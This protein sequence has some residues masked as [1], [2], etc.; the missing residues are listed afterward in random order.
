MMILLLLRIF[1][2]INFCE[3][4]SFICD[5][6]LVPYGGTI[7]DEYYILTA[8]HCVDTSISGFTFSNMSIAFGINKL[9]QTNKI[10]RRIKKVIVHPLWTSDGYSFLYDIAIISLNQNRT[11]TRICLPSRGRLNTTAPTSDSLQQVTLKLIDQRDKICASEILNSSSQFCA[12]LYEG[13]KGDSGGPIFQWIGD[14]WE[15]IGISSYIEIG[16]AIKGYFDCDG[17][18]RNVLLSSNEM[19]LYENTLPYSWS[20]IVSIRYQNQHLCTGTILD[21]YLIKDLIIY[22]GIYYLSENDPI[23][24]SILIKFLFIQ[25]ITNI[26]EQATIFEINSLY[27]NC[28]LYVNQYQIQFCAGDLNQKDICYGGDSG[29]SVFYWDGYHWIQIGLSSYCKISNNLGVFTRLDMYSNW[30]WSI[31][32][33]NQQDRINVYSCDTMIWGSSKVFGGIT[34]VLKQVSVQILLL[35]IS[36][37]FVFDL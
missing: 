25:I 4:S 21:N 17:A 27:S 22:A 2:L 16:C 3:T 6:N 33:S 12:G 8:A 14:R 9:S 36:I 29:N 1:L 15:Q 32:D 31:V 18:C 34:D 30:I 35:M 7:L 26:L 19:I 24:R 37:D 13:G 11:L 5:K 23:I 10:I 20:I 28:S